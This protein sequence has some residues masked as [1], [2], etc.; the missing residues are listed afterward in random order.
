MG[1]AGCCSSSK[2][3][4]P[5]YEAL[6]ASPVGRKKALLVGIN[7]KNTGSELRGC[8]NDV[9]NMQAILIKQYG[10]KLEDIRMIN[11]DQDRSCWPFKKVILDGMDWLYRDA[12]S[13]DVLVFHYSGHGSQYSPD[14][15]SMPADCICPL[16]LIIERKWP[17]H[18]ILDTEIHAKLY[19]P[20]PPGCKAVCIF[21]CCH[22]ATVAN[23]VETMVVKEGPITEAKKK[24]LVK[25]LTRQ[26]DS[27]AT[28]VRFYREVNSGKLD[29]KKKSREEMIQLLEKHAYP[30][31]GPYGPYSDPATANYN[32]LMSISISAFF[33][34]SVKKAEARLEE[35]EKALAHIQSMKPGEGAE[36]YIGNLE[37][38]QQTAYGQRHSGKDIRI[39]Y[40]PQPGREQE[41]PDSSKSFSSAGLSG[42]LTQSK[43]RDHQLWV[44]SGCQDTETS[45]DAH[46]DGSYQGAFT[47]ALLKALEADGF[48]ES[49]SNLLVQIKTYLE[50]GRFKQVPAL[51]T[52]HKTYLDL[53]FLGKLID[54]GRDS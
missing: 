11:E 17:D 13:G 9:N 5:A 3:G 48:R 2:D 47:W 36:I 31:K 35:K 27:V 1:N 14:D 39:R 50:G 53:G 37:Q 29:I 38:D 44:F 16:D 6:S 10:F 25:E 42:V 51:S 49:Y 19:D 32:Y 21:D 30:K 24:K 4:A 45:E 26:R 52:T 54:D 15:K 12:Q 18:V 22:S 28:E 7:Y 20:L 46:V 34:D 43:Y 41:A 33:E 23:L 8:I 40:L